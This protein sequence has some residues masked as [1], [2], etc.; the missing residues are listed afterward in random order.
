MP[1]RI[2]PS[3]HDAIFSPALQEFLASLHH[4]FEPARRQLLVARQEQQRNWDRGQRPGFRS[5]SESLRR[6]PWRVDPAPAD[7]QDRRV[8]ITGPTDAKMV[9][10]ALNSGARVFMADFEDAQSPGWDNMVTGQWNLSQA[11]AG[12]LS[13][14]NAAGRE[15]R[16]NPDRAVLV[17]RPRGWHL[18]EAHVL[19]DDAPLAGALFDFGVYLWTNHAALAAQN[20][21]PYF[22]L[23]KLESS[24]EAQL[25]NQVFD[26]SEGHLGLAPDTVKAT[27]L[28]ETITAALQMDE[29]L[30][31]LRRHVVGLNAGRW[32]YLFSIIKTFREQPRAILPDRNQITM[33]VPFMRD[34]AELL[35]QTAH[36]RGAHAIGGMAAFIP[37]RRDPDSNER[38]YRQITED[39][40]REACQGFDGTW[41]AHPDLVRVAEAPFR[42]T[43]GTRPHQKH[44]P[45]PARVIDEGALLD[46][47]IAD[48]SITEAGVRNN[49]AVA[50]QY[51][52]AWL[53]GQGA[54]GLYNL[55]EDAA[56]AEIARAQLFQWCHHRVACDDGSV[57]TADLLD[58][59]LDE[60]LPGVPDRGERSAARRLVAAS[61]RD[62]HFTEFI[63]LG[64]YRQLLQREAERPRSLW[65]GQS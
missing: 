21:G 45:G 30:Y 20:T 16:L 10:N 25:W 48:G 13:F 63:T 35:V 1:V 52:D 8:E 60:L 46:F 9:I 51:L 17:V 15:Y 6:A 58:Q 61:Y 7:L 34:F 27:V 55:M 40:E 29:I 41:V 31:A 14:T 32:D 49:L 24:A 54:V 4:Q 3:G 22:Y 65:E 33:A 38:A 39:K 28:I 42:R 59:W 57:V 26:F 43:L 47:Q 50:V 5:D 2:A 11:V 19:V 56:T 37:S 23:P 64:A 12:T 44:H 18:D 53:N 36:R 62:T